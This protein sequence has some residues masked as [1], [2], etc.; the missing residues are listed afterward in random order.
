MQAEETAPVRKLLYVVKAK[1]RSSTGF[2]NFL[3]NRGWD[4]VATC[5]LKTALA[6]LFS[7]PVHCVLVTVEHANPKCMR[8]PGIIAQTL[9]VPVILF[10]E[11]LSQSGMSALRAS[12]HPYTLGA[13]LSGPAI[14]RMINK[15]ERDLARPIDEVDATKPKFGAGAGQTMADFVHLFEGD[16][17]AAMKTAET[18]GVDMSGPGYRAEQE[19]KKKMAAL[20]PPAKRDASLQ[21]SLAQAS[22]ALTEFKDA[23]SNSGPG[24][25]GYRPSWDRNSPNGK[26]SRG[27]KTPGTEPETSGSSLHAPLHQSSGGHLKPSGER[28]LNPQSGFKPTGRDAEKSILIRGLE[29]ALTISSVQ[30][31]AVDAAG[32]RPLDRCARVSCFNVTSTVFS[33]L[34]IVAFGAD[35]EIDR[36]FTENLR[37]FF[38]DYLN[39]HGVALSFDELPDFRMSEVSFEKWSMQH[40]AFLRKAVHYDQEI[41][42]SFFPEKPEDSPLQ[43]SAETHMAK[44]EIAEI[45]QDVH[46]EF[47]IYL[48]FP[49]NEKYI[50]YAA[51]GRT[52]FDEQRSRI[53]AGGVTHVHIRKECEQ[54][55]VRYRVQNFLNDK[56][57]DFLKQIPA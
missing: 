9:K 11:G 3:R 26:S 7:Q 32:V 14:E 29:H 23:A 55:V 18:E 37:T 48:Y 21:K 49:I 43:L 20:A 25:S 16:G 1:E 53:T 38:V 2:E 6:G 12:Q 39:D 36:D 33:G 42:V 45:R 41:A 19:L 46:L 10:S 50:R 28:V 44:I 31:G 27:T 15:I 57:R 51:K 34:I 5:D 52:M 56:I 35:R 40:A 22:L 4:I 30:I 17:Q 24:G 47:D 13:P 54:D 8:L